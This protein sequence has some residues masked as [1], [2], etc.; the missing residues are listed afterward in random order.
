MN[1]CTRKI[2]AAG[3]GLFVIIGHLTAAVSFTVTPSVVSN[4][5]NGNITLLIT[6]LN[7]GET[8]TIQ[9]F[10]DLNTNGVIDNT[11]WLVQQFTL[12][13]GQAGMVIGGV[14]NL[15]VPYDTDSTAGQITAMLNFRNGDFMQNYVGKYLYRLS[16]TNV[17]VATNLFM[18]TNAIFAQ[19]ISGNVVNTSTNVPYAAVFLFPAPRS[20]EH[21]PGN[22]VALTVANSTG[23]YS[24]MVPPGTY[25]PMAFRTNY[26]GNYNKSPVLT[27]GSG[28]TTNVNLTLTNATLSISGKVVDAATNSIT[29]PGIF[30]PAMNTNGYITA[31]ASDT[32]GN[33]T[34]RVTAGTWE[35]A[36]SDEGLYVHGY[37][38]YENKSNYTAGATGVVLAYARATAMVYGR[39]TDTLGNPLSGVA[40]EAYDQPTNSNNNGT[41]DTDGWTDTNGNYFTAAKGA[42]GA[43][44][45]W[46][47]DV[48]NN[49]SFTNYAFSGG[50]NGVN[51]GTGQAIQQN[52]TA[53][54]TSNQ[55]TG[56]VQFNGS[57][58]SGVQVYADFTD[59]AN[60]QYQVQVDTD[61]NGNYAL[62][63]GNGDWT[64]GVS[65]QGGDDSLDNILG[66]G[67][68]ECPLG[69]GITFSNNPATNDFVIDSSSSGGPYQITGQI[70]DTN[71][72]PVVGVNVYGN[73]GNGHIYTTTTDSGGN[74]Q[75]N[76]VGNGNVTVS[77]DCNGLAALGYECTT[78]QVVNISNAGYY[79][80]YFTVQTNMPVPPILGSPL[81][82]PGSQFRFVINGT[83]GSNYTVLA[84]TNFTTWFTVGITNLTSS[85]V[86]FQD[87][88]ATNPLRFYRALLGP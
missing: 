35:M 57:P 4:T 38:G 6:G 81:K 22:P 86:L 7:T 69:E 45:P 39:V 84:S 61:T 71:G 9:K 51:I 41:Y 48:D 68:Y 19:K 77:V 47:M 82:P 11:D 23:G 64:L 72:N 52:F 15:N 46:N 30:E 8:V 21:G 58:V 37:V 2:L 44:D 28:V 26:L 62:Y 42:L 29:L 80:L 60:N 18:V 43:S 67:S 3:L 63:A 5:F 83:A 56:S 33:F 88:Q 25:V 55:V 78:G 49:S 76:N 14:T 20:G 66:N 31:C 16:R 1:T 50:N 65:C 17:P 13:D 74:Y 75:L 79:G 34:E 27:L 24:I 53:I 59:N 10:L 54:A 85:S 87:N 70:T 40:I 36:S 73:D 32:N 12:T